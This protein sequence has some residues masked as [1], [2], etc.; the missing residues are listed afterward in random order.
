[1]KQ[2]SIIINKEKYDSY[3]DKRIKD[4]IILHI[5]MI[6]LGVVTLGLAYP[7]IIFIKQRADK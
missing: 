3:F 2:S 1:M 4:Y 5:K 6:L 7:W